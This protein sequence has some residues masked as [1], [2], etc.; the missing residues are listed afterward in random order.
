MRASGGGTVQAFDDDHAAAVLFVGST[1]EPGP[2]GELG[3]GRR[4]ESSRRPGTHSIGLRYVRSEPI[5]RRPPLGDG[6]TTRGP[7]SISLPA[8]LPGRRAGER[9]ERVAE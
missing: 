2:G 4:G 8:E 3:N 5:V 1:T 6:P 9:S 7:G